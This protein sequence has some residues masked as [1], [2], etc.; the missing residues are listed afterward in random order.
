MVNGDHVNDLLPAY[1]LEALDER[2]ARQVASHLDKCCV[3]QEELRQ[4]QEVSGMLSLAVAPAVPPPHLKIAL[5]RRLGQ[6][7]RPPLQ[8]EKE[9]LPWH[10]RLRA[11]L[12]STA[13]ALGM[14]SLLLALVLFAGSLFL[15]QRAGSPPE[16][17][18]PL[19]EFASTEH[20][21][22]ARAVL[23]MSRDTRTGTLVVDGLNPLAEDQQYQ[24]WL[25]DNGERTSG[26]VFSVNQ[27]GYGYL[28]V[29][30]PRRLGGFDSFGV[31][32]EPLGGSPG[33][34]GPK[35]LGAEQ[36]QR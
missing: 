16:T 2:E 20:A 22:E 17:A 12:N 33:P 28:R 25:I 1:V 31:T 23:V 26:G 19:L 6:V 21:P 7:H 36:K 15:W 14:V 13:P 35:V 30:S 24:L 3:C 5:V 18:L 8:P 9:S 29:S 10:I 34:T 11:A 32:V 27:D 4:Y